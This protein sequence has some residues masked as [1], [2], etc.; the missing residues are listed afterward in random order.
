MPTDKG[1]AKLE[2]SRRDFLQTVGIGIP[3]LSSLFQEL[4]ARDAQESS[5]TAQ[6][7]FKTDQSDPSLAA[8]TLDEVQRTKHEVHYEEIARLYGGPMSLAP[9]LTVRLHPVVDFMFGSLHLVQ[10][11]SARGCAVI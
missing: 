5:V 11:E 7:V 9:V 2:D 4:G 1:K 3:V 6:N 8:F 10:C